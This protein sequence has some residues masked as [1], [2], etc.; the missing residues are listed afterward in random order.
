MVSNPPQ[1]CSQTPWSWAV[2]LSR[3]S[4]RKPD[5]DALRSLDLSSKHLLSRMPPSAVSPWSH[6]NYRRLTDDL[7]MH[8]HFLFPSL[9]FVFL[10]CLQAYKEDWGKVYVG[11]GSIVRE[12]G[13][14]LRLQRVW[15]RLGSV[16]LWL[17]Y[18]CWGG[19]R[20]GHCWASLEEGALYQTRRRV[21]L[22]PQRLHFTSGCQF[23]FND[24]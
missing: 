10:R 15:L 5:R 13:V 11:S 17:S 2:R 9:V 1:W 14:I 4:Q 21:I 23:H 12:L 24:L 8:L 3:P 20:R 6:L 18:L 22:R 7:A 19:C 16:T